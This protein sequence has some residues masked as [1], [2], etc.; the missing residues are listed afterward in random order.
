MN[1]ANRDSFQAASPDPVGHDRPAW[2]EADRL[3]AL[4]RY[5]AIDTA[6]EPVFDEIVQLAS[7]LCNAPLC[8]ICLIGERTQWFKAEIGFG[9]AESPLDAS[10]CACAIRQ[11][12]LVVV[13]DM[14]ADARFAEHAM[15][16]GAPHLR[17]YA[18]AP[19]LT[20]E[21]LPIGILCVFDH[22]PRPAGL[23][24]EQ[25]FA[26]QALARQVFSQFA[27]RR[28]LHERD[29]IAHRLATS[30][31]H[32]RHILS[33][34]TDYAII[35]LDLGGRVTS[36]SAGAVAILGW[37]DDEVLGQHARLIFTP[38]DRQA[39]V[40]ETEMGNALVMG[41]GTDER[42]HLRRDNSRFWASGEMMPLRDSAEQVVG[43][44]KILRDRTEQRRVEQD[45][46]EANETLERRV[47]EALAERQVWASIVERTDDLIAVVG[48]DLRYIAV[49]HAYC[50]AFEQMHGVA[51]AV[52]DSVVDVLAHD[53][54]AQRG[55]RDVW[56]RAL[57]GEEF[58]AVAEFAGSGVQRVFY[59]Q[60]YLT[61]RNRR[62][63]SIGAYQYSRDISERIVTERLLRETEAE[64]RQSQKMEAIGQLTGGLAHD[65]NNILAGISGNLELLKRR[66][67][68]GGLGPA[69]K[70]VETAMAAV[71][72]AASLTHR[73]LAFA[74]RQPLDVKP[75]DL[76]GLIKSIEDLLRRTLGETVEMKA[77]LQPDLWTALTDA[78]Q[79][80]N[81]LLNLTI[82]SRDAMPNGGKLTIETRNT[83]LDDAYASAQHGLKPG[84]YVVMSVSDTGCGMR[85][86]V[87]AKAFDPF[88]TTKPIGQGTGLGLSMIYGFVRQSGGH[89]RIYSEVGQGTTIKLYLPRHARLAASEE[90]LPV[91]ADVPRARSGETVLVVE[92]DPA[93]RLLIVEVLQDLG[94]IA[95]EASDANTAMPVAESAQRLDLLVTDVGLPGVN[96]RQ[97]AEMIRQH[98]PALKVLFVTG[99]AEGAAVRG[100]FL[101]RG[102]DMITKPF[103]LDELAVRIRE[104]IA[105]N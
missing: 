70:Y 13:P 9:V 98:R 38:E 11:P 78:H 26:L 20:D 66:G 53:L 89:I 103:A 28:A 102:M 74:R 22:A 45:R 47:S 67:P 92:D 96:G 3:A 59:E 27:L 81:A 40:P 63:A 100:G 19:L 61:L 90:A 94:Y 105:R 6:P 37:S 8:A 52:G 50:R 95:V 17:F 72:R 2:T 56:Q 43:F 58:E 60:R 35:T 12:G 24:S 57:A 36:W 33:S 93:V 29:Q 32:Y 54:E 65:F 87:V 23:S 82:N 79:F 97:L 73:L 68:P 16:R 25:S 30:E 41:R 75:T 14:N 84:D 5:A 4:G 21:G 39:Q 77:I 64:L 31:T 51:V 18:G 83:Q 15:V 85:A 55:A 99:Y 88:F 1:P 101:A 86:G 42:W 91:K 7:R 48:A 104:M 76:N 44:V 49:N 46:R 34:A 80:E 71:T 69:E 10:I 62:G